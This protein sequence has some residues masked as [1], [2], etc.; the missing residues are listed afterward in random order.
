VFKSAMWVV[1]IYSC[2]LHRDNQFQDSF[3]SGCSIAALQFLSVKKQRENIT[4]V[5]SRKR[6]RS[7]VILK[8]NK[9]QNRVGETR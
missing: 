4:A 6:L 9:D 3:R 7:V 2:A 8:N 1:T 5:V